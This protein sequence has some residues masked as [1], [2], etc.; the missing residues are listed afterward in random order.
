MRS[1]LVA[2]FVLAA[3]ARPEAPAR[4]DVARAPATADSAAALALPPPALP[5]VATAT[6]GAFAFADS[7]GTRLLASSTV[8]QRDSLHAAICQGG[9]E[10]RARFVRMQPRSPRDDGRQTARNFANQ[11]GALYQVDSGTVGADRTCFLVG[12]RLRTLGRLVVPRAT[13]I[14]ACDAMER[15]RLARAKDRAVDACTRLLRVDSLTTV[16][17]IQ[18]QRLGDDLLASIALAG[19]DTIAFLDFPA[20]FRGDDDTWRVGDGGRFDAA[21]FSILFVQQGAGWSA[22]ALTWAGEEGENIRLAATTRRVD[23]LEDAVT[24]YR[25]WVP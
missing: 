3:C 22:I 25:Y 23:V 9:V 14:V 1:R 8:G 18:F 15:T 17:G 12:D 6:L 2:L 19:A 4:Q 13:P 11:E 10:A 7:S 24:D 20:Q 5:D 16:Y 21:A